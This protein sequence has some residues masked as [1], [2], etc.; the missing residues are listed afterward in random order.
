MLP[1]ELGL[2]MKRR[3]GYEAVLIT[4]TG[5]PVAAAPGA[6]RQ[7]VH[8]AGSIAGAD[9]AVASTTWTGLSANTFAP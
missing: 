5:L 2:Y 4:P 8:V 9:V 3:V 1:L 7:E 6:D